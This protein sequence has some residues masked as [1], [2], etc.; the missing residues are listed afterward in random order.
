MSREHPILMSGPMVLAT[1][2]GAKTQT[3]REVTR[4]RSTIGSLPLSHWDRLDWASPRIRRDGAKFD[5]AE[6][7]YLLTPG[8]QYLHVPH[9]SG[10][11]DAMHGTIHRVYS[12]IEP[13]DRL[14]VRETWGLHGRGDYTWWCHDSIKGRTA[15]DLALSYELAYAADATSEYDHWRPSIHMPRWASRIT[16][17][18]TSIRVQR[19]HELTK[20]DAIAE[21][22]HC[23]DGPVG[24]YGDGPRWSWQRP[25]PIAGDSARGYR[26]CLG[27]PQMAFANLW[28]HLAGNPDA[29]DANPWVW[30]L[31]F[32]R[33]G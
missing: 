12:R 16:L 13:G 31:S 11:E 3:R 14:W 5:G 26:L 9:A 7:P 20:A 17:E 1:L 21:G 29:W 30:A 23:V 2:A 19:L 8:A 28:N 33:I 6:S 32:K 27:S 4:G 18:V 10:P 22:M 15:D 25:H 24:T